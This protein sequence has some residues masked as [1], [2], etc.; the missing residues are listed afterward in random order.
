MTTR[1]IW[2]AILTRL[3]SCAII[4]IALAAMIVVVVVG[5]GVVVDKLTRGLSAS[6]GTNYREI[7]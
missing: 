3:I 7:G 6:I 2:S 1:Q 5:S 4:P